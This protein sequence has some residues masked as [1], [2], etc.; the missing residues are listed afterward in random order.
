MKILV[1]GPGK[2]L[3]NL[4]GVANHIWGLKNYWSY[5]V[6]YNATGNRSPKHP[7]RGRWWLLWDVPKFILKLIIWRPDFVWVNPSIS[8]NALRR[9]FLFMRIATIFNVRSVVFIHGFNLNNFE[10]MNK[11][12]LKS[13]LNSAAFIM[14]LA[15]DFR[16]RLRDIGVKV[17][18]ELT[19]TKVEDSLIDNFNPA[20]KE[21]ASSNTLLYLARVEKEKGIY[22]TI[23]TYAIL[24]EEFPNLKLQ[25]SGDGGELEAT[26]KYVYDR[27]LKDITFTGV[28]RGNEIVKA[29]KNALVLLLPSHGEGM[30]TNVLEAMSFGLP[31]ATRPVGGLADFFEDGRMG[32]MTDSLSEHV[33]AK[34]LTPLI[35]DRCKAAEIG[36]YNAMYAKEHFF[37]SKVAS[38]VESF[39]EK[40]Q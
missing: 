17:P 7:G 25:I 15:E 22:E 20:T 3:K 40:Y 13:N 19:S 1:N 5:N 33:F 8:A 12:W 4:G 21:Y 10:N 11:Q 16:K 29:Y 32:V 9:D 31:V 34:K 24:K 30:P 14:V 36:H 2:K 39:F 6:R 26:K 38:Q 23:D 18:I 35:L 28:I 37:A 27:G